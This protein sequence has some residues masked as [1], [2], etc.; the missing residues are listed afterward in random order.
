MIE[1]EHLTKR[2]GAAR[3]V[4]DLS[5]TVRAGTAVA[6]WGHNGAGK[7][8]TLRC[9]LGLVPF[10]GTIRVGGCDV[11]GEPRAVRRLIGY[12]PQ[13]LGY[14]DLSVAETVELFRALKKVGDPSRGE[15][16]LELVGLSGEGGKRAGALS[17]GMRQRLALAL[18]LLADPPV[19]LL[20]EPTAS[21]DARGRADLLRLLRGCKRAGKTL[22]FASHRPE[23]V[24]LLADRVLVLENGA[25]AMECGPEE[26]ARRAL[27]DPLEPDPDAADLRPRPGGAGLGGARWISAH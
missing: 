11:R 13:S 5:F 7:T 16:A 10:E 26:F 20:D 17:G 1:V 22:L 23:E 25:L 15:R 14:Y 21:L 9:V 2:Y 19:L 12:V 24:R 27:L 6:M 8:T 3:A 18:A 4:A